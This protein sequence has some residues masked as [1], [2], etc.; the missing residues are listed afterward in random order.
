MAVGTNRSQ[1]LDA[2]GFSSSAYEGKVNEMMHMNEPFSDVS[3]D[4]SETEITNNACRPV[5]LNTVQPG[6]SAPLTSIDR[7]LLHSSLWMAAGTGDFV[8]ECLSRP[9][10]KLFQCFPLVGVDWEV[11]C[12][13]EPDDPK[14][15]ERW[16]G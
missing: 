9:T 2:V 14:S 10:Q 7:N 5:V 15:L 12:V 4:L 11:R 13:R 8:C 16:M 3:I 1:I 6:S